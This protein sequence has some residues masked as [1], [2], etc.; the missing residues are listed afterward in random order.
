MLVPATNF[1]GSGAFSISP[2]LPAG[3]QLNTKNGAISGIPRE[4]V[5]E[6]QYTLTATNDEGSSS[7]VFGL[8]VASVSTNEIGTTNSPRGIGD[9][10]F[11]T[12]SGEFTD[13]MKSTLLAGLD[14]TSK[15]APLTLVS[16]VPVTQR[17][18]VISL[19]HRRGTAVRKFL[20]EQGYAVE[21]KI[22]LAAARTPSE[23]R[24][25]LLFAR[26]D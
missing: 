5:G 13:E 11:K 18:K 9:V 25:V 17:P 10:Q 26:V 19:A 24:R 4:V 14:Q 6:K 21:T 15:A 23:L 8:A 20:R 3:L 16:I 22:V 12:R 2:P 1:G 7:V